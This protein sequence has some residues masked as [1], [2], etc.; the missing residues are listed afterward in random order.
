MIVQP[1]EFPPFFGSQL[2]LTIQPGAPQ[3]ECASA[4]FPNPCCVGQ[5]PDSWRRARWQLKLGIRCWFD[6][7]ILRNWYI[8]CSSCAKMLHVF[9][10]VRIMWGGTLDSWILWR[11]WSPDMVID[12]RP[13]KTKTETSQTAWLSKNTSQSK[14]LHQH[15][16][17][18]CQPQCP[19]GSQPAIAAIS[20]VAKNSK[21]INQ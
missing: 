13:P 8:L 19:H 10:G 1:A 11:V 5:N 9:F 16:V 17:H 15:P 18:L 7:K 20:E 21:R 6:H 14:P 12:R 4:T 3:V 2:D